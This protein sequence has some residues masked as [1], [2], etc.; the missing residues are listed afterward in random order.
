M[1]LSILTIASAFS[2][3]L[4]S[5]ASLSA[6]APSQRQQPELVKDR[7]QLIRERKR[8]GMMGGRRQIL[9]S[10]Q[11]SLNAGVIEGNVPEFMGEGQEARSYSAKTIQSRTRFMGHPR[12][13][14]SLHTRN[15]LILVRKFGFPSTQASDRLPGSE[16]RGS[17]RIVGN[18]EVILSPD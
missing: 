9:Q 7:Q 17:G 1:K 4:G 11:E 6:R 18:T 2:V 8:P 5:L 16:T 14:G 10:S 15:A 12:L 3:I 13:C